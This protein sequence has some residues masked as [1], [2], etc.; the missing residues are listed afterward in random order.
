MSNS[1]SLCRNLAICIGYHPSGWYPFLI[2]G[3]TVAVD[4]IISHRVAPLAEKAGVSRSLISAIEAPGLA[5]GFSLE[6]FFD[7][8]DA[9]EVDPA[10]LINASVFPDQLLKKK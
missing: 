10:D 5:N 4:L 8:A 3:K 7:I 2:V 9:L 6:V 1:L